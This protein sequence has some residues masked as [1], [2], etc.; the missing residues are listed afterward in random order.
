MNPKAFAG[1]PLSPKNEDNLFDHID[2]F[3]GNSP[4]DHFFEMV[5]EG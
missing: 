2:H 5:I 1:D 3:E 4:P